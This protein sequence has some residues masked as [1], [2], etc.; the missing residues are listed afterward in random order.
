MASTLELIFNFG[1]MAACIAASGYI[2]LISRKK[3]FLL[4]ILGF[5]LHFQSAVYMTFADHHVTDA[6][7]WLESGHYACM[8]LLQK[9]SIHAAQVGHYLIALGI[10]VH[11]LSLKK[12][13]RNST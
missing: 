13:R 3:A 2:Y 1:G 9:I 12:I 10:A 11:S 5:I 4:L 8:P 7:C 6:T